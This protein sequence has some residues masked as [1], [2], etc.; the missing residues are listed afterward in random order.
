MASKKEALDL[1]KSLK[2]SIKD[3]SAA[4][5]AAGV[6]DNFIS[7]FAVAL[8]ASNFQIGLLSALPSLI[9]IELLSAKFM[10]RFPRKRIITFGVLLQAILWLPIALLSALFLKNPALTPVLL[11]I[12]YAMYSLVGLFISPIWSSWMKDIVNEEKRGKYFGTRNKIAGAAGLAATL[13]AGFILDFFKKQGYILL[14]FGVL[15]ILATL[16]KLTSRSYLKKQYEPKFKI[17]EG[18]YF[19]FWQFLKKSFTN[20][21]GKFA[22]FIALINF[23]VAI[24][25]PFFTPYMLRDL[26]L[27]Y[28][29]FIML[30]LII[31][32]IVTLVTM[33][34]WGILTDKYGNVRIMQTTA[35]LIPFI[36]IAWIIS[37]NIYWLIFIQIISGI[38]WAG[39]NL[40][41]GN[42]TYDAVTPQ[43]MSICSAYML[44]L[45]GIGVFLGATLGGILASIPIK[46]M[47]IFFFVF[48]FSG[49][50]RLIVISVMLKKIKEV[51][52]VKPL[53]KVWFAWN[54]VMFSPRTFNS[55]LEIITRPVNIIYKAEKRIN[56]KIQRNFRF[57]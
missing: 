38:T 14:G 10:E 44:V 57:S 9:P 7:P 1:K 3:G 45:S 52:P 23:T 2:Y 55:V 40:A 32:S 30:T 50:A 4:S 47:N 6:G 31:P 26:G 56:K 22:I 16:F 18:Y 27:S 36:P 25:G 34:L 33:P 54:F 21:Y 20:N 48:I 53:K 39:F 43:R 15:F 12:F 5:M 49:I 24:S 17:H 51:R 29:T 35:W 46:F 41:A 13:I 8:K 37:P 28:V 19:S 11:I 42:F